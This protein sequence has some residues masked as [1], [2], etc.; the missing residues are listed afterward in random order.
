MK[1]NLLCHSDVFRIKSISI[2]IISNHLSSVW[3]I[4][5]K[6]VILQFD[7]QRVYK[8]IIKASNEFD[9]LEQSWNK[10]HDEMMGEYL[11]ENNKNY[12]KKK[13]SLFVGVLWHINPS[14]L[15]NAKLY[16]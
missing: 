11:S 1:Q 10:F 13:L 2:A 6:I 14:G 16:I 12:K 3:W 9:F 8:F 5:S 7:Y 15:F 4:W